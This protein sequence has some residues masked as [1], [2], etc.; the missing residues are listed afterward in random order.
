MNR[1]CNPAG[2]SATCIPG[3]HRP[4]DKGGGENWCNPTSNGGTG[5][6]CAFRPAAT[7]SMLQLQRNLPGRSAGQLAYN[8]VRSP[9]HHGRSGSRI[10]GDVDFARGWVLVRS[11]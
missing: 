8:E 1:I 4:N 5:D 11:F 7:S 6:G 10:Y 9:S 3:C 2:V